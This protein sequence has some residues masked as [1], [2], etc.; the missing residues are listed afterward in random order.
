MGVAINTNLRIDL[1]FD[2]VLT[3]ISDSK[4]PA[5]V[6]ADNS[7]QSDAKSGQK[8]SET[9]IA[10]TLDAVTALVGA[11]EFKYLGAYVYYTEEL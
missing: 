11:K 2:C 9:S 4:H 1:D 6:L 10:D 8:S 7:A 5:D 3:R